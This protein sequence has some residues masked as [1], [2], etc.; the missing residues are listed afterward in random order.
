MWQI[1]R[2]KVPEQIRSSAMAT[3]YERVMVGEEDI[4]LWDR[5]AS[6]VFVYLSSQHARRLLQ[7]VL[8]YFSPLRY[9]YIFS[10]EYVPVA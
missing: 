7:K 2:N 1:V 5:Y 6:K 8:Q 4:E 9:N 10:A 3:A